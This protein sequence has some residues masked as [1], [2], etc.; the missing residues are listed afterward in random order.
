MAIKQ[1]GIVGCGA[2]GSGIV[3]VV[4]QGGYDVVVHESDQQMLDQG[5]GL[6]EKGLAKLSAK[7]SIS[8]ED[9]LNMR[10]R[11]SGT[12]AVGDL[13]N[14]DLI[15]EAI[16]E[17]INVK[18][19]LFRTLDTVCK[20]EAIFASNT[21]SLSI[22]EMSSAT[23]RT[24]RFVGLHFFNPVP[25]MPLVE[26]VKT[27][28]THQD[29]IQD[30]LTFAR[31]ISKVPVLAKDQAGFIVNLLLTPF[32]L[33]AMRAAATGVAS[34]GDIDKAMK[35][36]CNHPMGPLMLADFIGLDVIRNACNVMFEEYCDPRYAPPPILKKM[37]LVGHNGLK[38][39]RGF[40]DWS[41]QKKP[42]PI[43]LDD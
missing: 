2:M 17:E 25:M 8:E 26:V 35:L 40:Y 21:S 32:M 10:G 7:G 27:L 9:R 12:L 30:V 13:E 31:S 6:V 33:D 22:T 14:C 20:S 3:Q 23:H 16:F 1:V 18:K 37:V 38:S 24:Q 4:L 28:S 41:D 43:R 42:V 39:G 11:L 19:E 5:L 15:I 29:V 36:G 34:I